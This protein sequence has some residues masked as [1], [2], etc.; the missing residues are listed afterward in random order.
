MK[1]GLVGENKIVV[2]NIWVEGAGMCP[3]IT[4]NVN[5]NEYNFKND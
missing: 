3:N 5:R 1:D 2:K 4:T